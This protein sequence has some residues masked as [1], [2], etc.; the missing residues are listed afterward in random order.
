MSDK[1]AGFSNEYRIAN[2]TWTPRQTS[3]FNKVNGVGIVDVT[4]VPP[5][6]YTPLPLITPLTWNLTGL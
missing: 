1:G 3:D 6:G 5:M 2:V 4:L